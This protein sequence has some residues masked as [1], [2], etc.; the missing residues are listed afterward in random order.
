[1]KTNNLAIELMIPSQLNKDIIFNESM[2]KIDCF[3]NISINGFIDTIDAKIDI[4]EKYIIKDGEHRNKIC[5]RSAESKPVN[6]LDPKKGMVIYVLNQ[7]FHY[8]DGSDWQKCSDNS[9]PM[10]FKGINEHYL[11]NNKLNYLY[12]NGDVE[13]TIDSLNAI[14]IS[15]LLKQSAENNFQVSWPSNILWENKII[16]NMTQEKN[17]MDLIKLYY[18]PE[19]QHWLAKIVARNFNY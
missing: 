4:N 11:I 16:H 8:F 12:L 3:F 7:D 1:M 17:S 9:L 6:L 18:L 14:E 10:N 19:T 13:L 15:I 2:L 5:Y